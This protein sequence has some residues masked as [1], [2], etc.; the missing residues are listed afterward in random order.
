MEKEDLD[1]L[2]C[3]ALK[4]R[5]HLSWESFQEF[6]N[7][8]NMVCF[9]E[10]VEKDGEINYE[11]SCA[12]GLKGILNRILTISLWS[13]DTASGSLLIGLQSQTP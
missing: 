5:T 12:I 3:K 11:C 10:T 6:S 8:V 7:D 13:S 9:V 2:A 1:K 4:R